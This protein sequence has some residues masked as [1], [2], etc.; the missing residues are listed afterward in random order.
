MCEANFKSQILCVSLAHRSCVNNVE[1]WRIYHTSIHTFSFSSIHS[2][3]HSWMGISSIKRWKGRGNIYSFACL[4]AQIGRTAGDIVECT[5]SLVCSIALWFIGRS[6]SSIDAIIVCNYVYCDQFQWKCNH[7]R[8]VRQ[9]SGRQK[10]HTHTSLS[11]SLSVSLLL[12]LTVYASFTDPYADVVTR[13]VWDSVCTNGFDFA[14]KIVL[15]I[16]RKFVA[17]AMLAVVVKIMANLCEN[18]FLI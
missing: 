10:A 18:K 4:Q 6:R 11:P 5:R 17:R 9:S 7:F 14:N 2:H 16:V 1:L 15:L 13:R 12:C 3:I 8:N